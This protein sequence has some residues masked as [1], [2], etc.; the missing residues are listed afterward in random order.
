ML[1]SQTTSNGTSKEKP[2]KSGLSPK[3]TSNSKER[4]EIEKRPGRG[5]KTQSFRGTARNDTQSLK[6]NS[7][8][9]RKKP[10]DV[11]TLQKGMASFLDSLADRD[12]MIKTLCEHVDLTTLMFYVVNKD[13]ILKTEQQYTTEELKTLLESAIDNLWDEKTKK[14]KT[15]KRKEYIKRYQIINLILLKSLLSRKIP[16]EN[17]FDFFKKVVFALLNE[18]TVAQYD[19]FVW[20]VEANDIL[21]WLSSLPK[22]KKQRPQGIEDWIAMLIAGKKAWNPNSSNVKAALKHGLMF[23]YILYKFLLKPI[24]EARIKAASEPEPELEPE[25]EPEPDQVDGNICAESE[26]ESGIQAE[27]VKEN[28]CQESL[29]PEPRPEPKPEPKLELEPEPQLDQEQN[30]TNSSRL[31]CSKKLKKSLESKKADKNENKQISQPPEPQPEPKLQPQQP[32][33]DILVVFER[34]T[35]L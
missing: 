1:G 21:L 9:F 17:I 26:S 23:V 13:E 33:G 15:V 2:V 18:A 4:P 3:M 14:S 22:Y 19:I 11:T 7:S 6:S 27:K 8:I 10:E 5:M 32:S 25:L 29:H 24:K 12:E 20:R 30:E 28:E 31:Q 16:L 35:C 34:V